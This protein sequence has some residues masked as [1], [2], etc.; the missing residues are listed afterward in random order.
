VR[1]VAFESA[2]GFLSQAEPILRGDEARTSLMY[3]IVRRLAEGGRY[4]D[5]PPVLVCVLAGEEIVA[6]A[7]RTPPYHLIIHA[8]DLGRDA[9]PTLV[10]FLRRRDPDL[11]GVH[12][13]KEIARQFA[14][15][16][17]E[18]HGRNHHVSMEQR[19]YRLDE[20]AAVPASPGEFRLAA[21][22]DR[23]L[24][25]AWVCSFI[26]EATPGDSH[27]DPLAFVDRHIEAGTLGVWDHGGPRTMAAITRGTP[28]GV[29]VSLVFTP[30]ESRRQGY[31]SSCV[32]ALS[33]RQLDAGKSFCTLFTD[34]SN[35]TSNAIYQRIGYR[36]LADITRID[37]AS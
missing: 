4:G 6:L 34:L 29:A 19:L 16:W 17:T 18:G 8:V 21:P 36:P 10:E 22:A 2:A 24:L 7:T 25:A 28:R 3:G 9:I 23:D 20:V 26:T 1:A 27:P 37:F 11:P 14:E 5:E 33:Q 13:E 35:P 32:A 31:A 15:A 12:A 30:P